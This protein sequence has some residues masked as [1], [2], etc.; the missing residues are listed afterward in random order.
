M[1]KY[2]VQSHVPIFLKLFKTFDI[3][4][5]FEYGIGL[6]STP[7]FVE[8]CDRVLSIEMNTH[9]LDGMLWYDKVVQDIGEKENWEH[10]NMPGLTE[11]IEYGIKRFQDEKFDLV[12]ADG[13]GDT[14]G[15]Q[16]NTGFGMARFVVSHDSQHQHTRNAW[17]IQG[18]HQ[19][20]FDNYCKSY[21][22]DEDTWP[23]TTVFC[24]SFEDFKVVV[25]WIKEEEEI[26]A[27]H[28]AKKGEK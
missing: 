28:F 5:V 9:A 6:H 26:C 20:D 22:K 25:R 21:D 3:K 23:R 18:Y 8:N 2:S 16:A 15:Q 17:D 24:E 14:R 27:E 19:I 1:G 12:F 10:Y 13:H 4:S 11:A 7:L